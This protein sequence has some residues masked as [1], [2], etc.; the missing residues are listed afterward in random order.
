MTQI[1]RMADPK[2]TYLELFLISAMLLYLELAAIRW[3]AA[4][5]ITLAFFTNFVLMAAFVGMSVGCLAAQ[6]RSWLRWFP[7]LAHLSCILALGLFLVTGFFW[8]ATIDVQGKGPPELVYFGTER[9]GE[10]ASKPA[11]PLVLILAVLFLIVALWFVGVG[12]VMGRC[13][14]ALPNRVLAYT[15]NVAGS[16]A[17]IVAFALSSYFALAPPV[18]FGLAF[19]LVAYFLHRERALGP[20]E[21]TLLFSTWLAIAA[22]SWGTPG[23]RFYW[24]PY[25]CIRLDRD[26]L[27]VS[28]NGLLHQRML[29]AE[30]GFGPYRFPHALQRVVNGRPAQR[31]LIIGA[32]TGNDVAVALTEGVKHVD[33]VE[34][35]PV[36]AWL[37]RR[38]H[39]N[40]PYDDPRVTLHV[41]DGRSFLRRTDNRYDLILYGLIDSLTLQSTYS[42]IRLETYLF[43]R[44][45]FEAVRE[46]LEPNGL[47][48]VYN[49]FRE[50]WLVHRIAGLMRD[51]F[52]S[53]PLVVT[54]PSKRELSDQETAQPYV[55]AVAIAR[56]GSLSGLLG[57]ND[58]LCLDGRLNATDCD[59]RDRVFAA[60]LVASRRWRLPTDD[61][62]FL[63]LRDATIPRHNLWNLA[64]MIAIGLGMIVAFSPERRIHLDPRFL[65]LGAGFMLIETKSVVQLAQLF[66]ST[67]LVNTFVFGGILVMI[68][69]ANL[70]VLAARRIRLT[71]WYVALFATLAIGWA[72]PLGWLLG[73]PSWLQAVAAI[74]LLFSPILCAGVI[75]ASCFAR[76]ARP[77]AAFGANIA[78][79]VLGGAAEYVSLIAGYRNLAILAAVFY[80][81]SML[82]G[83]RRAR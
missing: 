80:L 44:E 37:G 25:Y 41:D 64:A 83:S 19:V 49:I 14:E 3:F 26:S 4:Y 60:R 57:P 21:A 6:G 17:G 76:S 56:D 61:W 72:V 68:L 59:A 82:P 40:R 73:L 5:V 8:L 50:G 66:G 2:R 67:W 27:N 24:S 65:F 71:P 77:A 43:T 31:T 39:P 53:E 30:A 48:V 28:V 79:A 9:V 11:V 38:H 78:G 52:G 22:A 1:E 63:Y 10:A 51:V 20:S 47:F 34:I 45:A 29:P 33:A 55:A 32:G 81:L 58:T 75:F 54:F 74:L 18:W 13:F 12:Q 36:I 16:L 42:S 62:P 15:V 46:R 7:A 69:V 35:D 70:I 23:Q